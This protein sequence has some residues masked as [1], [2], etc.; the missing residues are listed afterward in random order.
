M[1][2]NKI[3]SEKLTTVN[4]ETDLTAS[5]IQSVDGNLLGLESRALLTAEIPKLL[6]MLQDTSKE[7]SGSGPFAFKACVLLKKSVESLTND[8]RARD[9]GLR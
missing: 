5:T 8:R 3:L 7:P 6:S 9:N 2:L 1:L 4:S